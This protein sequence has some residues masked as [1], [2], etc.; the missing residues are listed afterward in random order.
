MKSS[1]YINLITAVITLIFGILILTG[2]LF[3]VR[4]NSSMT[5]FGIVLIIYGIYR[6]INLFSKI[7]E[8]KLEEK[9]Q[10]INEEKE[11]FLNN[12]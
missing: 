7:K 5:M 1:Y 3:P 6:F 9:R 4:N 10:K 8:A 12:L 11:K 2:F